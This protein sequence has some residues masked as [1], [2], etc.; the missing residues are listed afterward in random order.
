MGRPIAKKY[1]DQQIWEN[2]GADV[3][4]PMAWVYGDDNWQPCYIVEQTAYNRFICKQAYP[5]GTPLQSE[6]VLVNHDPTGPG[7]MAITFNTW[8]SPSIYSSGEGYASSID[9]NTLR[10]FEGRE[11][12]WKMEGSYSWNDQGGVAGLWTVGYLWGP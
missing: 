5:S 2:T 3:I 1:Y 12:R 9:D 6:C 10:D 8:P 4:M 11:V 7:Q